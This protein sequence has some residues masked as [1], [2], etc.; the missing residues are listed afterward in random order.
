MPVDAPVSLLEGKPALPT[1]DPG[2][3]A[4]PNQGEPGIHTQAPASLVSD[5]KGN[6][7]APVTSFSSAAV[8]VVP[9]SGKDTVRG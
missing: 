5:T 9:N 4:L 1:S 2:D 8:P 3:S 6:W 7:S